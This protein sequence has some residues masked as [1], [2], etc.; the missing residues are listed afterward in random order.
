MTSTAKKRVR[1]S[2]SLALAS[3]VF[4]VSAEWVSI[5]W[6]LA[7]L[8]GMILS[9]MFAL[10]FVGLFVATAVYVLV[11]LFHRRWWQGMLAGLFGGGCLL[12]VWVGLFA[13]MLT[14]MFAD[15]DH[16]ADGLELPS[17][18]SLREPLESLAPFHRPC[19]SEDIILCKGQQG[20]I[21]E[22]DVWCNPGEPGKLYLR[23][24]EITR[25]VE[26]SRQ[27]IP[28]RTVQ[29]AR[30]DAVD[31]KPL[32]HQMEFTVYEGKW[33]Q[34]YGARFEV[35]FVPENGGPE[36]MLMSRKYRIEGWS[37]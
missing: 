18:V 17:G 4:G 35:W 29:T 8:P 5:H 14:G 1:I 30:Y 11:D 34:N 10:T 26:L 7:D 22:A 37:R 32:L 15:I 13:S 28:R 27:R 3:L 33:G 23:A 19:D 36:R 16:F 24:F 6:P 2:L 9:V 12:G 31:R 20:G 21:Y 25:G